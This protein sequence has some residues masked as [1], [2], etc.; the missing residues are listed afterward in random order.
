MNFWVGAMLDPSVPPLLCCVPCSWPGHTCVSSLSQSSTAVLLQQQVL[1]GKHP[2]GETHFLA[3]Q[4]PRGSLYPSIYMTQ[5]VGPHSP[6]QTVSH[7]SPFLRSST[8]FLFQASFNTALL[9]TP[10]LSI[11]FKTSNLT[12]VYALILWGRH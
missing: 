8:L 12:Q 3:K 6:P 5:M 4:A 10:C 7:R 2:D 1:S 9:C 11:S